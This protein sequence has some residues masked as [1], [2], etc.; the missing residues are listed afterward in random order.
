MIALMIFVIG[1]MHWLTT[2]KGVHPVWGIAIVFGAAILQTLFETLESRWLDKT[3]Y[4]VRFH[5]YKDESFMYTALL[6]KG[7][8]TV[9]NDTMTTYYKE[10]NFSQVRSYIDSG[11]WVVKSIERK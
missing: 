2:V 11:I 8:F 10:Y 9:F 1:L 4:I 7:K 6:I 3:A 5:F